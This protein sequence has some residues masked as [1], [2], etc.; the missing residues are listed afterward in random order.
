MTHDNRIAICPGSYDPITNGHL[1]V[2]ARA[3]EIS[4]TAK[5]FTWGPNVNVTYQAYKDAFGRATQ[6]KT[7]FSEAMETM[8]QTTVA[9]MEKAGFTVGG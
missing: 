6:R 5:G 8:Q 9:D 2:I 4:K 3:A 7:P 1:D